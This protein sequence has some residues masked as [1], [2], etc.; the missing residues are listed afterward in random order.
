MPSA[1]ITSDILGPAITVSWTIGGIIQHLSGTINGTLV[2]PKKFNVTNI[3]PIQTP[4]QQF[5][6]VKNGERYVIT[7]KAYSNGFTSTEF[8]ATIRTTSIS[9][10]SLMFIEFSILGN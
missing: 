6:T 3:P 1:I 2:T 4:Q 5:G 9:M 8:T 10:L 7:V